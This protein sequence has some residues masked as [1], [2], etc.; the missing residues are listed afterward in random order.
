M[1]A[2]NATGTKPPVI[3]CV[4]EYVR[5]PTGKIFHAKGPINARGVN[6][7]GIVAVEGNLRDPVVPKAFL[8]Q[9]S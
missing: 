8:Q 4:K 5:L 1:L 2:A 3:H 9:S 7:P 6:E